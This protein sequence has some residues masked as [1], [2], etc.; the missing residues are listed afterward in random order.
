MMVLNGVVRIFLAPGD[1]VRRKLGIT[2]NEDG[3]LIRSFVNM[4]FW[5]LIAIALIF[6]YQ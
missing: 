2:I 3:G 4:C 1:L 5:G 6:R